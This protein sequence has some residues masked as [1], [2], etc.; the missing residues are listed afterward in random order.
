MPADDPTP[1]TPP[2]TPPPSAPGGGGKVWLPG[3][4]QVPGRRTSEDA[5]GGGP[6]QAQAPAPEKE[7]P[8]LRP[9]NASGDI[10]LLMPAAY[11]A[12]R[13]T[14]IMLFL[15]LFLL[16]LTF[17]ILLVSISTVHVEKSNAVMSSLNSAFQITAV[18]DPEQA[19]AQNEVDQSLQMQ[20]A[21]ADVFASA[22]GVAKIEIMQRGR[23]MRVRLQTR[24][25]FEDDITEIRASMAE[26]F[27]RVITAAES[28]P[29]NLNLEV[30]AVMYIKPGPRGVMPV[31]ETLEMRRVGAFARAMTDRG[32]PAD[33]LA[34][35]LYPS[36]ESGMDLWFYIRPDLD[37]RDDLAPE[38]AA[39][40]APAVQPAAPQTPGVGGAVSIELPGG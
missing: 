13:D 11:A 27:D 25:V 6:A 28:R 3:S 29:Q 35:G 9:K 12:S 37:A 4:E 10:K 32:M 36:E 18:N 22:L 40:P 15:G 30:E 14:G 24:A 7:A 38:E 16:V 31:A 34:A 19:Q 8:N 17:F 2:N 21:I 23:L 39:A 20:D 1:P 33:L 5:E 26:L